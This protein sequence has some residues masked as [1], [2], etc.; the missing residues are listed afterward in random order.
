MY[1]ACELWVLA[2]LNEASYFVEWWHGSV[3]FNGV[4]GVWWFSFILG[5]YFWE[6]LAAAVVLNLVLA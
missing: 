2:E 1:P 3:V 5:Q 4:F 6:D